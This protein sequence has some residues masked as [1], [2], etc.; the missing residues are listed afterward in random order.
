MKKCFYENDDSTELRELSK[1][2]IIFIG[3]YA[4]SFT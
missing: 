1:T 4:L 2:K 3:C